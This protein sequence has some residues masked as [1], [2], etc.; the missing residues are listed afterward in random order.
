MVLCISRL[1]WFMSFGSLK[2]WVDY[3]GRLLWLVAAVVRLAI[4][5]HRLVL[6]FG[7]MLFIECCFNSESGFISG[8]SS[9]DSAVCYQRK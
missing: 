6:Q 5:K 1:D 7:A 3:V 9:F 4:D 8:Y 2:M